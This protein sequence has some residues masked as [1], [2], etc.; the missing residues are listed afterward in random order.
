MEGRKEDW[1]DGRKVGWTTE[2]AT[3]PYI[4]ATDHKK[5]KETRKPSCSFSFKIKPVNVA[6]D[7]SRINVI[8]CGPGGIQTSEPT[9]R[10]ELSGRHSLHSGAIGVTAAINLSPLG[11]SCSHLWRSEV[12]R[13]SNGAAGGRL[14]GR[15][16][17]SMAT[18]YSSGEW[19]LMPSGRRASLCDTAVVYKSLPEGNKRAVCSTTHPPHTVLRRPL[20]LTAPQRRDAG[21]RF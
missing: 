10:L 11:E 17:V 1:K 18:V 5:T 2:E 12:K 21:L 16:P 14:F 9:L 7:D 4:N 13:P 8:P 19:L 20:D 6:D 15:P 3:F